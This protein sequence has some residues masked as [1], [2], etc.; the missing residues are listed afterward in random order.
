MGLTAL[1]ASVGGGGGMVVEAEQGRGRAFLIDPFGR[2]KEGRGREKKEEEQEAFIEE[3]GGPF[4]GSLEGPIPTLC[5]VTTHGRRRRRRRW[6]PNTPLYSR[7]SDT[8][9][10]IAG[11]RRRGGGGGGGVIARTGGGRGER[12]SSLSSLLLR[13][14]LETSLALS[15][16]RQQL[17]YLLLPYS[18]SNCLLWGKREELKFLFFHKSWKK[19][20]GEEFKGNTSCAKRVQVQDFLFL[21]DPFVFSPFSLSE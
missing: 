16:L 14:L 5:I 7:Y 8:R 13:R 3:G 2:G 1:A 21:Q 19:G 10:D 18:T 9:G 11:E 15:F 4:S 6:R 17:H 20:N 12:R